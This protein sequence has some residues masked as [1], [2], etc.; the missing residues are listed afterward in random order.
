MVRVGGRVLSRPVGGAG[1]VS[2]VKVFTVVPEDLFS[3]RFKFGAN[4]TNS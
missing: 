3:L 4:L 2:V 1:R